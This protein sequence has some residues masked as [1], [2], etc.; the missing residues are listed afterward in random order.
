M[1]FKKNIIIDLYII[2]DYREFNKRIIKN[3]ILLSQQNEI[4]EFL[5]K[6]IIRGKIDLMNAYYQILMHSDNVHKT[7][8][9]T[10]F[11]LYE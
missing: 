6:I 10:S 4:L 7:A 11:E 2:H 8:F 3:Y 1:T 5:V 9:K